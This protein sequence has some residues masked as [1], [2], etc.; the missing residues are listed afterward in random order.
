[1]DKNI[2]FMD[3]SKMS[4]FDYNLHSSP[5]ILSVKKILKLCAALLSSSAKKV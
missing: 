4:R 1:M 5:V 2:K 3:Y